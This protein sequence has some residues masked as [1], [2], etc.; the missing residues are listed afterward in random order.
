MDSR[1]VPDKDGI[2][3]ALTVLRIVADL[4]ADGR[5]LA[6]LLDDIAR[7]HGLTATSQLSVRVADLS[8]IADAMARLRANP[9]STLLGAPVTV[10][11]LAVGTGALPPTDGV[12]LTGETGARGGA[13]VGH[14][15]EAQVL[16]GGPAGPRRVGRCPHSPLG[17]GATACRVA[18]PD[19]GGP[20]RG[21]LIPADVRRQWIQWNP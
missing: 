8:L 3:A 4:K 10:A 17:R 21:R 13:P 6:D 11:D 14:R 7:E 12:E 1:A 9:P 18:G 2:T 15:A 16:P 20:R 5:T 19:G